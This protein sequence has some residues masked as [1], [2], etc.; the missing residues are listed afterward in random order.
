MKTSLRFILLLTSIVATSSLLHAE[1]LIVKHGKDHLVPLD[2]SDEK[3]HAAIADVLLKYQWPMV[4][5]NTALTKKER[6]E[7]LT[8][9]KS[10]AEEKFIRNKLQEINP[11][12]DI[13]FFFAVNI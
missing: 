5:T 11:N 1:L 2:A 13:A 8:P 6:D 10:Y 3:N 9:D 4:I 7:L 12:Y